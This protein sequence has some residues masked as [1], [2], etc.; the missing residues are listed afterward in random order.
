[1]GKS[2][3][4]NVLNYLSSFLLQIQCYSRV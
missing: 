4:Q 1:M 2:I 3:I